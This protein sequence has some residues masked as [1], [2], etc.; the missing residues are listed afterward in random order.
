MVKIPD[1]TNQVTGKTKSARLKAEQET[2]RKIY[3]RNWHH[4]AGT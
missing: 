1:K 4:L 2:I 3:H